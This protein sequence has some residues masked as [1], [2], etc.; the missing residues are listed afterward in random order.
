[1]AVNYGKDI[2][3]IN[4]PI[5][6]HLPDGSSQSFK[7]SEEA[8][9]WFDQNYKDEYSMIQ[10]VP[11]QRDSGNPIELDEVV[12]TAPA[13]SKPTN[14]QPRRGIDMFAGA[15]YSPSFNKRF[16]STSDFDA[17][18]G[19]SRVE[20]VR[21]AWQRNPQAMQNWTDGGNAAAAFITTPFAAYAAGEYALPWLTKNVAPYLS[22]R[23]W[24]GAT[25]A[26]GN[27]PV[28]LTPTSATA[29]DAALAGS[30]TGASINDMRENGPTI[31]NVL[32][33]ILGVGGLALEAVP[34][35]AEGYNA[36]RNI[37]TNIQRRAVET[38]MRTTD[39]KNPIPEIISGFKRTLSD[40]YEGGIPRLLNIGKYILT[41]QR[42][43]P[44]GYYN[45]LAEYSNYNTFSPKT[46][47]FLNNLFRPSGQSRA[48]TG[49]LNDLAYRP[50]IKFEGNDYIDAFLYNK[51]ID[52]RYGLRLIDTNDFGVHSNY[53]ANR[54]G[55]KASQIK[56]YEPVSNDSRV[57]SQIDKSKLT[58]Y[59]VT[60]G[61][62]HKRS[63]G[64]YD[65]DGDLI[66]PNVGGHQVESG[67]YNGNLYVRE[68]DIWKFNPEDYIN[69]NLPNFQS[70]P[71]WKQGLLKYGLKKVDQFGT[72]V[73]TRT[74]WRN[75]GNVNEMITLEM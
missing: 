51:T 1:M 65:P 53:I 54:Y 17:L 34:T 41:G 29:I 21:R 43:G 27:T 68:Q 13:P 40:N 16:Y 56:T 60:G 46:N 73:I 71:K 42:T 57:V 15:N 44:K 30:A 18:F 66:V 20:G 74:P 45:S 6:F 75:E 59:K 24:L 47:T 7:T 64:S 4:T 50:Y 23:G 36:A 2:S 55:P 62:G 9:K 12:V 19:N 25:Q 10:Y 49:F 11:A 48:Y 69:R 31:S 28:W 63:F 58:D 8:Q 38:A 14:S 39:L 22:A 33:T 5:K 35:V 61:E 67:V 3:S 32:G 72:P 52:P 26:A 70:F 37:G